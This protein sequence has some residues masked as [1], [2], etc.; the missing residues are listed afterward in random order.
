MVRLRQQ[1]EL[2]TA[3]RD[4]LLAELQQGCEAGSTVFDMDSSSSG[5]SGM[6]HPRP[7]AATPHHHEAAPG[8]SAAAGPPQRRPGSGLRTTL[9]LL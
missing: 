7:L 6:P 8:I 4:K 9:R 2:M 5:G 1:L 3:E